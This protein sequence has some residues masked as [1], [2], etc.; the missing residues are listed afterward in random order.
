MSLSFTNEMQ[1]KIHLYIGIKI[2]H[3]NTQCLPSIRV[4]K[5]DN[6]PPESCL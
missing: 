4:Q 1:M 3:D 5:R 6:F 2:L